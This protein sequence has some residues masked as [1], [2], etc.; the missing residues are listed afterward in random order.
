[1]RTLAIVLLV[2]GC[3][4]REQVDQTMLG[5]SM[6]SIMNIDAGPEAPAYVHRT[7]DAGVAPQAASDV[8]GSGD[9]QDE[10]ARSPARIESNWDR[11]TGITTQV[12]ST[13]MGDGLGPLFAVSFIQDGDALAI[14]DGFA[15]G[16]TFLG[17]AEFTTVTFVNS[18]VDGKRK[19]FAASS[20]YDFQTRALAVNVV[21]RPAELKQIARA[22]T[23]EFQIVGT[24]W[25]VS[26]AAMEV[27]GEFAKKIP[28]KTRRVE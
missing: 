6:V 25:S 7:A 4:G 19:Q 11:F 5:P 23:L 12:F 17:Y 14:A 15:G 28:A 18:L 20:N 16:M 21:L 1:M 26:P 24:E 9:D 10:P 13:Y 22:K 27:L 8:E 2:A 3:G